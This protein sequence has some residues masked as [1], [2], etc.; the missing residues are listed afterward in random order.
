VKAQEVVRY[1]AEK[2]CR[3]LDRRIPAR[4][5]KSADLSPR[6][7]FG[8]LYRRLLME[9]S[10]DTFKFLHDVFEKIIIRIGKGPFY[11]A[12]SHFLMGTRG[13]LGRCFRKC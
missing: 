2:L 3:N 5:S 4:V 9:L 11:G 6:I 12:K 13:Q 10:R 7:V 8:V 1:V